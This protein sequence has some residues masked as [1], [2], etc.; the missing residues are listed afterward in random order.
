MERQAR[1]LGRSRPARISSF[2]HSR[3][4]RPLISR[5]KDVQVNRKKVLLLEANKSITPLPFFP[6]LSKKM[7]N[8]WRLPVLFQIY[9]A[10]YMRVIHTRGFHLSHVRVSFSRSI[11][12]P[13]S[14][15]LRGELDA[16]ERNSRL[17]ATFNS[18]FFFLLL[19]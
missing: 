19:F 5:I 6:L 2:L 12:H 15:F 1:I 8:Q 14:L 16:R 7:H 17:K 11:N 3:D 9:N 13:F 10:T 4:G 18:F